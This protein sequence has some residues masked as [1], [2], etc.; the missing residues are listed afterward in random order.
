MFLLA[1][2]TLP[3]TPLKGSSG[4][5]ARSEDLSPES[6][7]PM[8]MD[9]MPDGCRRHPDFARWEFRG[10]SGYPRASW[11]F[12][13]ETKLPRSSRS[14]QLNFRRDRKEKLACSLPRLRP[15]PMPTLLRS[16]G[17]M[18]MIFE[19]DYS[20]SRWDIV[21]VAEEI[22]RIVLCFEL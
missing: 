3:Y 14:T 7:R 13:S 5:G 4:P 19:P 10:G 21:V 6:T 8:R 20:M 1:T 2:R 9:A 22:G 11:S 16:Q 15:I 17:S 12:G 18:R